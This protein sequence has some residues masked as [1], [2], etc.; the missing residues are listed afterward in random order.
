MGAGS[1]SEGL[2][3][4][5]SFVRSRVSAIRH[6]LA[7]MVLI[8]LSVRLIASMFQI[9]FDNDYWALVIRNI[10]AGE[11]L[12]GVVGYYYTPVWGYILGIVSA[13]QSTFLNLGMDVLRIPEFFFSEFIQGTYYSATVPSI[14]FSIT[15]KMPLILSDLIMAFLIRYLVIDSTGSDS[16]GNR[17]FML[18][19]LCP[20]LIGVSCITTMPD[21]I[22]AMFTLLTV[23]LIRKDHYFLAGMTFSVAVLTKFFPVFLLFPLIAYVLVR[24]G[25]LRSGAINVLFSMLGAILMSCII[26]MPQLIEGSLDQCFQFITDRTGNTYGDSLFDV[27][28]GKL[29]IIMYTL[30]LL[31]SVYIALRIYRAGNANVSNNFMFGAFFTMAMCMLYPPTP[32]YIIVIIPFLVYWIVVNDERYLDSW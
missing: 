32:Q 25:N 31:A 27:I 3:G 10:E 16:K 8:G 19:F 1:M 7:C 14:L 9:V 28:V 15:V 2:C 20:L 18:V 13:F 17:A 26:F 4:P 23:V 12:Y 29:R 22:S 5:I 6:P 21:T 30:V 24:G 11:G